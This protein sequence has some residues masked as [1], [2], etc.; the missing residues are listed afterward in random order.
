MLESTSFDK[1]QNGLN[2][3]QDMKAVSAATRTGK[4]NGSQ[5]S[6]AANRLKKKTNI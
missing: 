2:S 6:R 4:A 1:Q 5:T 3:L